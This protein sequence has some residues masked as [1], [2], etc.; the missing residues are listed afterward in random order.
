MVFYSLILMTNSFTPYL[1]L[2]NQAFAQ[3]FHH[4][5]VENLLMVNN[6]MK[7]L[8]LVLNLNTNHI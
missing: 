3:E 7:S 6:I 2:Y 5:F 4:L 8:K 1:L